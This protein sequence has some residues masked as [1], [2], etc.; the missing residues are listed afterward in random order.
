MGL[1]CC[2]Y[3]NPSPDVNSPSFLLAKQ[4]AMVMGPWWQHYCLLKDLCNTFQNGVVIHK[5]SE[6]QALR[7]RDDPPFPS[8]IS[9]SALSITC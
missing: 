3:Y 6:V 2:Y 4:M 5:R 1:H 9:V 7:L 8:L